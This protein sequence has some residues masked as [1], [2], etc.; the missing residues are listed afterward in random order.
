MVELLDEEAGDGEDG[1]VRG[2]GLAG[3]GVRLD[4]GV[5]GGEG[6]GNSI[7]SN[8]GLNIIVSIICAV[9]NSLTSSLGYSSES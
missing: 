7:V 3:E 1:G 8:H 6:K 4:S 5:G 2:E 9:D